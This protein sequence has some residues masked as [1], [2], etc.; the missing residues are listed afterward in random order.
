MGNY[1]NTDSLYYI[2]Y[3]T[4]KLANSYAVLLFQAIKEDLWPSA[5]QYFL[6]TLPNDKSRMDYEYETE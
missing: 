2:F 4:F 3:S 5:L 6:G 1:Q